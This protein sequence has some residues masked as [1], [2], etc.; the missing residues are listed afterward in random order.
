[1]EELKQ[2]TDDA[3]L[4]A[5]IISPRYGQQMDQQ[6]DTELKNLSRFFLKH[7]SLALTF[8]YLVASVMGL[9]FTISLLDEFQFYALPYLEL[10]DFLLAAISHPKTIL[11]LIIGIFSVAVAIWFERKCRNKYLRYAA[12]IDR[13]Y[14]STSWLPNWVWG[15]LAFV[16]Y[17]FFASSKQVPEIAQAIKTHQTEQYQ[18]SLIYP[19]QPGGEEIRQLNEVQIITR[20]VSYLWIYHQ[21][22]VKLI[23]HANVAALIPVLNK[24][25]DEKAQ[26]KTTEKAVKKADKAAVTEKTPAPVKS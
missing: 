11:D 2:A 18:L 1:M 4:S 22:Q 25:L 17:L 24:E 19:I 5:E 23:P 16:C 8:G 3:S 6:V 12:W 20:S 13:Y 15:F 26:L 9:I 14:H 7:P 10:T 21:D